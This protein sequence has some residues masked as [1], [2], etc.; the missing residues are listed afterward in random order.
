MRYFII[1]GV[2]IVIVAIIIFYPRNYLHIYKDQVTI[3]YE[4]L[5]ETYSE[6]WTFDISGD[7]LVL[8]SQLDK[9]WI[10]KPNKN[11]EVT[12]FFYYDKKDDT[13]RYM[14]EYKFKVKGNKIYWTYGNASGLLD[15]PNPE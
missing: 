13:E 9:K 6:L 11:G 1:F 3:N 5:E 7:N 8:D 4:D 10:F 14:I 15:F 12:I 2:T